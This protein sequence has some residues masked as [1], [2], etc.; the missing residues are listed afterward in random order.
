MVGV[1]I[2]GSCTYFIMYNI[3][4]NNYFLAMLNVG[5][6]GIIIVVMGE[7]IASCRDIVL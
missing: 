1:S 6:S 7:K 3:L 5:I 2:S 4:L